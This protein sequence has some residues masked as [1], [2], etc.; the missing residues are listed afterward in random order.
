MSVLQKAKTAITLLRQGNFHVI[1][2]KLGLQ[3]KLP[4]PVKAAWKAGIKHEIDFW[5]RYFLTKGLQWSDTYG[6]RLDPNLPLQPRCTALLPLS[7][8]E[9]FILD[10]GAGPLTYLGKKCAGKSLT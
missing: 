8:K 10:V 4:Q 9:V 3:F 5:D 6:R 7:Q 1:L 2:L